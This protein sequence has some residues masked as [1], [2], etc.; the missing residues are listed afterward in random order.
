MAAG[1]TGI[2]HNSGGLSGS[3]IRLTLWHGQPTNAAHRRTN[4]ED[5]VHCDPGTRSSHKAS[6]TRELLP[7]PPVTT[8]TA[9]AFL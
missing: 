3:Q 5:K 8:T 4:N 9:R 2:V 7:L 6:A 1:F